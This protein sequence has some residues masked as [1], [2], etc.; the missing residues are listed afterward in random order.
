MVG[1]AVRESSV[2]YRYYCLSWSQLVDTAVWKC[3]AGR[4]VLK[5]LKTDDALATDALAPD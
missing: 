4:L 2:A 5:N 3:C 1:V